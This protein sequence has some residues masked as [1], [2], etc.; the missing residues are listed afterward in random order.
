[1]PV[2]MTSKH[3]SA[4]ITVLNFFMQMF[5]IELQNHL[6]FLLKIHVVFAVAAFLAAN[7]LYTITLCNFVVPTRPVR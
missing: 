4:V 1:M 7:Q 5:L 2:Q 6:M 3:R